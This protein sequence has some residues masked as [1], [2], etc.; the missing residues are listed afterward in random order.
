VTLASAKFPDLHKDDSVPPPATREN[1]GQVTR[2]IFLWKLSFIDLP[3]TRF[4]PQSTP[5]VCHFL[6]DH[7]LQLSNA[8]AYCPVTRSEL[9]GGGEEKEH[10]PHRYHSD[11]H[12]FQ[13]KL[14]R[15]DNALDDVINMIELEASNLGRTGDENGLLLKFKGWRRELG[16]V[17]TGFGD[18]IAHRVDT[19]DGV[20]A[21]MG[22]IFTD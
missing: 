11:P 1:P 14:K 20:P 22:G 12:H 21:E 9:S 17:R 18:R 4:T 16:T 2:R 8:F 7:H 15:L 5:P 13:A 3:I 10:S 19:S 6:R